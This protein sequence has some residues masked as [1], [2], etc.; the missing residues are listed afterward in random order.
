MR[1]LMWLRGES[2]S[3]KFIC[4]CVSKLGVR[5]K[6]K[7][8]SNSLHRTKSVSSLCQTKDTISQYISA[9]REPRNEIVKRIRNH[10]I[11]FNALM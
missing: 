1:M 4:I 10:S 9:S 3:L 11:L 2:L 8:S 5:E 7:K 6:T